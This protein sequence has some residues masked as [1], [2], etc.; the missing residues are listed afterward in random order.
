MSREADS[1]ELHQLDTEQSRPELADLDLLSTERLVAL[2]CAEIERVPAAVAG[3]QAA[4]SRAVEGTVAGLGHGGRLVYVGAGTA[5]RI[6]M[7]DAAEAGPTFNVPSG[8]VIGVL[9][10]GLGAFDVPIE[11]AED[12]REA[13]EA[14]M[15]S[16]EIATH[17]VVVGIAASGRTPFVLGAIDAAAAAGALT[18]GLAC[19]LGTP[20]AE[21]SRIAIEVPVGPEIIAGST[22]LNAGTAQKIVLNII[23][24]AAMVELGKTYGGLMVDLRATNAKLRDRATRIVAQITGVTLERARSALEECDWKPKLAAAALFG[25]L[26]RDAAAATLERHKGRLRPALAE[27]E[28]ATRESARLSVRKSS[29]RLGVAGAYIDGEFVRGDVEVSDGR[30]SGIALAGHGEGYALPGLVDAQVNGYAGI[31]ILSADADALNALA[32]ALL[33][34][35]VFAYQPT[36]ISSS[37]STLVEALAQIAAAVSRGGAGARIIGTHLEGPFLSPTRAGTHPLEHLRA[38]DA[39][40]LERLLAAGPVTMTTLAPEL[41]GALML[42]ERCR[43]HGVVVSLGHSDSDTAAA[44]A[45]FGAGAAAVTHLFNAM[46][47]LSARAPGLAGAALAR[48]GVTVQLIAD[49]VHVADELIRLAFTAAAGRAM[50]VSD[51]IAAAGMG[52]GPARLGEVELTV[53]DGV[54]RRADG[55]LAGSVAPLHEGLARLVELGIEPMTAVAAASERP[56]QLLRR[57]EL[58]QLAFAG[59]ADLIV[60]D[61]AFALREVLFDGAVRERGDGSRR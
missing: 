53:A 41:P 23:S 14:A 25:G 42:V 11:N 22:R 51:T 59:R 18:V 6:G 50:I 55:T 44:T 48:P 12:D 61:T 60:V 57:P 28:G 19:N 15:R 1:S 26:D 32:H 2:M 5:G 24:T 38:P 35:G 37:E 13:G 43:A 46:A 7:L 49:R 8:Q 27:L 30:I 3:A 21:R 40:L 16:L 4:I 58:G 39:N 54:A 29:K 36:L 31:D 20:L 17:D 10:G 45:A 52:D 34:D 33:D 56:A 9:A 47:P